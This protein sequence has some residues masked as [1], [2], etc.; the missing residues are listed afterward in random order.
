MSRWTARSEGSWCSTCRATEV[1]STLLW[2]LHETV[3]VLIAHAWSN[4]RRSDWVLQ[5]EG[6]AGRWGFGLFRFARPSD[7]RLLFGWP[8]AETAVEQVYPPLP[9][10][11]FFFRCGQSLI[12]AKTVIA[13]NEAAPRHHRRIAHARGPRRAEKISRAFRSMIAF[14]DQPIPALCSRAMRDVQHIYM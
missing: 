13:V 6:R 8:A 1:D 10:F 14:R 12:D 5:E 7:V 4:K 9:P 3:I 11:F 2:V